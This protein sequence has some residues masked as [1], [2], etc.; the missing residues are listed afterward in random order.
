MT[1][2]T[3]DSLANPSPHNDNNVI[4]EVISEGSKATVNKLIEIN[5]LESTNSYMRSQNQIHEIFLE[6]KKNY[7]L[8]LI[9][10]IHDKYR[11]IGENF[12]FKEQPETVAFKDK[13]QRIVSAS[14]DDLVAQSMVIMA[15][16]KGWTALKVS[17]HPEF[18]RK[19]WMEASSRNIEV[20]G[21]QPTE[22][23]L[24]QLK[25]H[26]NRT[27]QN[28]VTQVLYSEQDHKKAA[29]ASPDQPTLSPSKGRGLDDSAANVNHPQSVSTPQKVESENKDPAVE[30]TDKPTSRSYTGHVVAHGPDHFNHDSKESMNYY[31]TLRDKNREKT[32]W[33][34]DLSRG[35]SEQTVQIGD[36][37]KLQY[38]GS[39]HVIVDVP[40]RDENDKVI[41]MTKIDTERN[42]WDVSKSDKQKVVE[43]VGSSAIDTKFTNPQHREVLKEAVN[44]RAA[45]L[46]KT[47]HMP[48]VH[49]YDKMARAKA[50]PQ[51]RAD[52]ILEHHKER[53]R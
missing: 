28:T 8:A 9:K 14:N 18:Q 7:Q 11:V 26:L 44:A 52:P 23:E 6:Q 5:D 45:E 37:V 34:L 36:H 16:A 50:P 24:K 53:T 3:K 42:E 27:L 30:A 31:V 38:V 4:E 33:G 35:M 39:K 41:G 12:H 49:V 29:I 2:Y 48:T 40:V 32:V 43:A 10:Q 22:Q 19:I 13:G 51:E 21:Y 1:E 17:G 15:E 46:A 25:D 47:G 20:Y